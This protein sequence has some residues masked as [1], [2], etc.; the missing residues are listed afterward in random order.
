MN[1]SNEIENSPLYRNEEAE[2][3]L[4]AYLMESDQGYFCVEGLRAELFAFPDNQIVWQAIESCA[5]KHKKTSFALVNAEFLQNSQYES[6]NEYLRDIRQ[7][8]VHPNL[9]KINDQIRILTELWQKRE[10][11]KLAQEILE[12]LPSC[13]VTEIDSLIEQQMF[14]S[15]SNLQSND[16]TSPEKGIEEAKRMALEAHERAKEGLS[17]GISTGIRALDRELGGLINSNLYIIGAR[18]GQGKTTLATNIAFHAAKQG[19]PVLFF[20]LEMKQ[21]QLF[22]R[23]II[24]EMK[25]VL[26]PWEIIKGTQNEILLQEFNETAESI[27]NVPFFIDDTGSLNINTLL[28]RAAYNHKKYN[29]GLIVIDYLQ[30]VA[31]KGKFGENKHNEISGI[32][33]AIKGMAQNLNVSVILLSQLNRES[34]KNPGERPRLSHLR[35]SG[36]IEAAG[37]VVI[38]PFLKEEK[39]PEQEDFI[40]KKQGTSH[41][42][43]C[44][45]DCLIIAKNR[46]GRAN[47][48]VPIMFD[49]PMFKFMDVN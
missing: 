43:K 6:L 8:A 30:L 31:S 17:V 24:S 15:F 29:I 37:N 20:S 2:Q 41:K 7:Y 9:D 5:H 18:P 14:N 1:N 35:D 27:K 39:E 22:Q 11:L 34:D 4:I 42:A 21:D 47:V 38:F 28:K 49:R 36:G 46:Q 45:Q 10:R 26:C 32:C 23:I 44:F 25:R 3:K 48:D 16:V 12:K 13:S 40:V 33:E 19:I